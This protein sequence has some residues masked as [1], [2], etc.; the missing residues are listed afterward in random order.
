MRD[1]GSTIHGQKWTRK[2]EFVC[3]EVRQHQVKRERVPLDLVRIAVQS[4]F[5]RYDLEEFDLEN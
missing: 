4:L 3:G 1:E 2:R 5:R